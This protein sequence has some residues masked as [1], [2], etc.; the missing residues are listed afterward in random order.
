MKRWG[1]KPPV[2][3]W[4]EYAKEQR[5]KYFDQN[6]R[7]NYGYYDGTGHWTADEIRILTAENRPITKLNFIFKA[8][9]ALSGNEISNRNNLY[10]YPRENSDVQMA[11]IMNYAFK[12][13]IQQ[14]HLDWR[15]TQAN[16]DGYITGM[17]FMKNFVFIEDDGTIGI[18]VKHVNPL[19][20]Y[21]DP[22]SIEYDISIDAQDI[23][24][25]VYLPKKELIN[26]YP[27]FKKDIED[28]YNANFD[29][30]DLY[31]DED[32]ELCTVIYSEYKK[33]EKEQYWIVENKIIR[34]DKRRK[35]W[36]DNLGNEYR[37]NPTVG[38][39]TFIDIKPKI[40]GVW[41]FGDIELEPEVLNPFGCGEKNF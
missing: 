17:G 32:N 36:Y 29:G 27:Q 26:R 24:E 28:F 4:W 3:E 5:E 8:I 7:E 41:H 1:S 35:I 6:S 23:H 10:I 30:H 25:V 12:Y 16:L 37:Q 40:Y 2:L 34:Y 21:L 18:G 19:L 39:R 11:N 38:K 22:D 20:I 14:N 13:I 31:V 9:N 15:F 33:Y